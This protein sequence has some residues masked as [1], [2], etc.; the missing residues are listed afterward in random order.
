MGQRQVSIL[1]RNFLMNRMNA[2]KMQNLVHRQCDY[3]TH[4]TMNV[5]VTSGSVH[6]DTYTNVLLQAP[7]FEYTER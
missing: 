2:P 4:E 6:G 7:V 5:H 3:H 1:N